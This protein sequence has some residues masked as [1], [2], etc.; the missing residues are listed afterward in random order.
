VGKAKLL[1]DVQ[2]DDSIAQRA[3]L[4]EDLEDLEEAFR[5][6]L[7]EA[8]AES[9]LGAAKFMIGSRRLYLYQSLSLFARMVGMIALVGAGLVIFRRSLNSQVRWRERAVLM[10]MPL[11]VLAMLNDAA[12]QT[13]ITSTT[14]GASGMQESILRDALPF[15]LNSRLPDFD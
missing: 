8:K 11:A 13:H 15:P 3:E 12:I 4:G 1:E 10:V 9:E 7:E 6:D 2:E 5:K 14:Q